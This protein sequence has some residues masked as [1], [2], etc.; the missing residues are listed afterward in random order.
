MLRSLVLLAV[1]YAGHRAIT[2]SLAF[3]VES[4][5][6]T[7]RFCLYSGLYPSYKRIILF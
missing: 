6:F 1:V 2:L 4:F 3:L 5:L 7:I